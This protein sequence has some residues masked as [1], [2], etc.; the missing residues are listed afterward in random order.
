MSVP[1]WQIAL[2]QPPSVLDIGRHAHGFVPSDRFRLED[3]WSLHLFSYDA[4]LRFDGEEVRVRPGTLGITPPGVAIETLYH[5][6]SVHIFAHFRLGPGPTRPVAAVTDLGKSYEGM[7][8]EL[9][10]AVQGFAREP[11]LASARVWSALWQAVV[12]FEGP[13]ANL[14]PVHPA[15]LRAEDFIGRNLAAPLGVAEIARRVDLAPDYLTRLFRDTFGET[16][17]EYIRRRRLERASELLLRSSLPIK[18]VAAA[19]GFSDL[20]RFN[21][22]IRAHFGVSPREYRQQGLCVRLAS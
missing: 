17:S 11:M 22:A 15:V 2:D 4:V 20:Q 18:I 14:Q 5:G 13:T 21:K 1:V 3:R 7:Y 9:F 8:G 16:V 10:D 12:L 19:V 6:L